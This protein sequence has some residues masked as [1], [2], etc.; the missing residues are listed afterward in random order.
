VKAA[1][2]RRCVQ[3]QATSSRVVSIFLD[4]RKQKGVVS[5]KQVAILVSM[6]DGRAGCEKGKSE[7]RVRH[8][9][10]IRHDQTASVFG[11]ELTDEVLQIPI[12]CPATLLL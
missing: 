12:S 9:H 3:G 11:S 6:V 2:S 8:H 5:V 10:Q 7:T 4:D 1:H